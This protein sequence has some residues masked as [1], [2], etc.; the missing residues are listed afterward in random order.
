MNAFLDGASVFMDHW[1]LTTGILVLIAVIILPILK[2]ALSTGSGRRPKPDLISTGIFLVLFIFI[3]ILLRL[4]YVSRAV[5]PLYFDSAQHYALIKSILNNEGQ[6][7]LNQPTTNYYH[8]GFHFLTAFLVSI[9]HVDIKQVILILGQVILALIPLPLFFLVWHATKSEKAG[10]FTLA[11]AAFGWYMPAHAVDWGKYP[12]LMSLGM[13]SFVLSLAYLLSRNKSGMSGLIH[14]VLYGLLGI[15]SLL[16]VFTHSRT[17]IVFGIIFLAWVMV[18]WWGKFPQRQKSIA[19]IAVLVITLLEVIFIQ[20]QSI[21]AL[22]F[23]PYLYKGILITALVLLLTVFAW[24]KYP[25]LTLICILTTTFLLGSIFIPVTWIPGY[26]DLTLLDRPF[27]EMILFLPLSLLGGLGLAGFEEK[28]KGRFSWSGYVGLLAIGI[29]VTNVFF[30]Y[31]FYPSDCCVI[32]G[33]NDVAAMGWM[34]NQLPVDARI[35]IASTQLKVMPSESSE[36]DVGA[37]AGIWITPLTSRATLLLPYD[38]GFDQQIALD[39]L[40]QNEI[41]HLFVGELGQTFD[42]AR[43]NLRPA[44]YRPLLAMPGTRVYE[45]IGCKL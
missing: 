37:D 33:N 2:S 36:G 25:R 5:F 6:L 21:L 24:M 38:A 44:W 3:S 41:S 40:C 29:V 9:F 27:V 16:A 7:L 14:W 35:G 12:A 17:L 15:S 31:D 4:A 11:L 30:T 34:A 13:I 19:F 42:I 1:R 22:L 8:L 10:W 18:S 26:R 45:V 32:V 39:A 20:R 23:D 28:S 43:L